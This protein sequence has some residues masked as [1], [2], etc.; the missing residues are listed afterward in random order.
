MRIRNPLGRWL[1]LAALL[2]AAVGRQAP[3]QA[4]ESL[5]PAGPSP[6]APPPAHCGASTH[7][8]TNSTPQAITDLQTI[9]STIHVSGLPPRIWDVQV[10]TAISHTF[11]GDLEIYLIQPD[12]FG[13]KIALSTRNG[14]GFANIFANTLWSDQAPFGITEIF[15]FTP[16]VNLPF[17]IPEGAMGATH[18][19]TPNG[20]W[21]LVIKDM[22]AGDTGSLNH[23]SL[24]ITTLDLNPS[25]DVAIPSYATPHAIPNSGI[26]T[27]TVHVSGLD[28]LIQSVSLHT[29]IRHQRSSDLRLTLTS[30]KGLTTTL[31]YGLGGASV[32]L[33]N[34][35]AWLDQAFLPITDADY[36]NPPLS[37]VQPMGAMG[38]FTGSDPNGT[39]TL[40][41]EDVVP[42]S[43]VGTLDGWQLVVNGVSCNA[44]FLPSVRR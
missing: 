24:I 37:Q 41:A 34:G 15:A 4:A 39:W 29:F 14:S 44:L 33:F 17:L 28:T 2:A 21:K 32:D 20:D 16:N 38:H 19:K 36:T 23:W 40:A 31:T 26:F 13:D 27:S 25:G 43:A 10:R 22:A 42:N 8:Y 35:T 18:N 3:A 12:S 9:T 11:P 7:T 30:P 6:S 5:D 1:V